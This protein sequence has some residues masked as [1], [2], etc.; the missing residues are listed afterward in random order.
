ML[1][2]F[3]KQKN[4]I[5][6]TCLACLTSLACFACLNC[7]P[8]KHEAEFDEKKYH[9][10]NDE[11]PWRLIGHR[12]F[13]IPAYLGS[14]WLGIRLASN[15]S[16]FDERMEPLPCF[17]MQKDVL[18]RIPNLAQFVLWVGEEILT[19][20]KAQSYL[21]ILDMRTGLFTVRWEQKLRND[22]D[23]VVKIESICNPLRPEFAQRLSVSSDE[24]IMIRFWNGFKGM[25]N[26][27]NRTRRTNKE[28]YE[29]QIELVPVSEG[30]KNA[31]ARAYLYWI[32]EYRIPRALLRAKKETDG[33][34]LTSEEPKREFVF[35]SITML[36]ESDIARS[37]S[38][39]EYVYARARKWWEERWKTDIEIEGPSQDQKV[40]RTFLFYLYMNANE[41]LP[42]MGLSSEKYRGHRFWDAEAWMLPVYAWIF[43]EIANAAT[44]WR[45][46]AILKSQTV[47]WEQGSNGLDLTPPE[48]ANALH[49]AGW[50][51]WWMERA[52]AFGLL[53]EE[54]SFTVRSFAGEQFLE[55]ARRSNSTIEILSV[56]GPDEARERNNDLVTNL[57]AKSIWNELSEDE[58][59]PLEKRRIYRQYSEKIKLPMHADGVPATYDNDP[60]RGYQQTSA[61]LAL[62]PL[63]WEF[64]LERRNRMF[65]LYKN[66]I[67]EIGPAMSDSIHATIAA[68]L[69]RPEEAYVLWKASWEP[70]LRTPNALFSEKR[71]TD[72]TYFLT[73]AAGCL[74]AV[75]YGF[76]GLQLE[77]GKKVE[78]SSS[79]SLANG[80]RISIRP[81]LPESWQSITFHNVPLSE[82][83]VT[84]R[85]THKN[86]R[87][88]ET[89][90]KQ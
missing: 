62:F 58:R 53:R 78:N 57:L 76:L 89:K 67:V 38:S 65:D 41:K 52:R 80:Y 6:K 47:P 74:Q 8:A 82:G 81:C 14:R 10:Q 4:I 18:C 24:P 60:L 90:R 54:E 63:E 66:K 44:R 36:S 50:V 43:P 30:E 39:F 69:N 55:H 40:V 31:L 11:D 5:N 21:S 71:H 84:I 46:N 59:V 49:V 88:Y 51:W 64:S 86:V 25:K 77:R 70:F 61:L 23:V 85:A 22:I 1:N 26:S 9:F 16:G 27:V 79:E 3:W 42:P 15:G 20:S 33:I 35:E 37:V 2:V 13:E 28:I 87:I 72:E 45:V 68:R 75:I 7:I 12:P 19:P 83:Y 17:Y 34:L 56:R 32:R 73:G 29:G 48:F